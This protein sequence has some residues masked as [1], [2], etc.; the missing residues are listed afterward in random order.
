M[1]NLLASGIKNIPHLAA[2]SQV[3]EVRMAALEVEAVLVY[4]IDIVDASALETLAAQLDILG[5]KG[6]GV[7]QTEAQKRAILKSAIELHRYKGTPWAIKEALRKLGY[8]VTSIVERLG[9]LRTYNGVYE[10]NGVITYSGYDGHWTRFRVN[11]DPTQLLTLTP[12]ELALVIAVINEY[13]NARSHLETVGMAFPQIVDSLATDIADSVNLNVRFVTPVEAL[14]YYYNARYRYDGSIDHSTGIADTVALNV[15]VG[16][17]TPAQIADLQLW[18]RPEALSYIWESSTFNGTVT[19]GSVTVTA[20][21]GSG[22]WFVGNLISFDGG[23]T[24]YRINGVSGTTLT[25]N[26]PFAGASGSYPIHWAKVSSWVDSGAFGRTVSAPSNARPYYETNVLAS[27]AGTYMSA[28]QYWSISPITATNLLAVQMV[29]VIRHN[30]MASNQV[31]FAHR[32]TANALV[33]LSASGNG[34]QGQFRDSA[35]GTVNT[36][37]N[38]ANS[39]AGF[40]IVT[41]Q[42]AQKTAPAND[43]LDVWNNGDNANKTTAQANL[44]GNFNSTIQLLGAFN[45]GGGATGGYAGEILEIV[46]CTDEPLGEVQKIEGYLAHKYGLTANL[47]LSHPYKTIAP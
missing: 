31:L 7:A 21:G 23:S 10:H 14:G 32:S 46:M 6:Y 28:P 2:F 16:A 38:T 22:S 47:P 27:F 26:A 13:K 25:L 30:A 24:F 4:L 44:S 33:Q 19:N 15:N 8:L 9:T 1:A 29:A 41:F 35:G 37:T 39:T 36:T 3:A 34:V 20:S 5:I 42:F 17:W 11:F 40:N 45:T 18:L 12:T 43:Y